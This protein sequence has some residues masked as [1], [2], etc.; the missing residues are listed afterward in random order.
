MKRIIL[1]FVMVCM[2]GCLSVSAQ[3]IS[4]AEDIALGETK[5]I[6]VPAPE[7]EVDEGT[8]YFQQ[9]FLFTPEENGRY[10]FLMSYEED[11]QNP[12]EVS[13]DVPGTY[14]EVDHGIEFEATAGETYQLCFQYPNHD[15]RY[16]QITFFLGTPG[17]EPI[18]QTTDL[19][20]LLPLFCLILSATL[21]AA[22]KRYT[23]I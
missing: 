19:P 11:T 13:L 22:F 10:C 9:E 12:Y 1:L 5:V 23:I 14:W 4:R 6:T 17:M 2:M 18:P 15:G 8:V 7:G 21:L 20:F 3:N 16:P